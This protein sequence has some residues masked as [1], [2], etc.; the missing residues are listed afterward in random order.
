MVVSKFGKKMNEKK[1]REK[2]VFWVSK[3]R[4]CIAFRGTPGYEAIASLN[5]EEMWRLIH[6]L[7]ALGFLVQ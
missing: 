2:Y 4:K 3:T 1:Q 6:Q 5:E 7:V